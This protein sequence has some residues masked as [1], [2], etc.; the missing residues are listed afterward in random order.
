MRKWIAWSTGG[1]PRKIM[2]DT[3]KVAAARFMALE[4]V[5]ELDLHMKNC[6]S[7]T[8][9]GDVHCQEEGVETF[10]RHRLQIT[11]GAVITY[12]PASEERHA[13]LDLP[14]LRA[15]ASGARERIAS[16]SDLE[17]AAL[18]VISEAAS[19]P[20]ALKVLKEEET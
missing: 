11:F 8:I 18:Q 3:A 7:I 2:A 13:R 5:N 16:L 14:A 12:S 15:A 17:R 20:E 6:N 4:A 9:S 1:P 19:S 10:S